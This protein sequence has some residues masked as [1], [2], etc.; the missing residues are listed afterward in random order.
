MV[1]TLFQCELKRVS[2]Q[3]MALKCCANIGL[4]SHHSAPHFHRTISCS[5]YFILNKSWFTTPASPNLPSPVTPP[6]ALDAREIPHFDREQSTREGRRLYIPGPPFQF[7]VRTDQSK[8]KQDWTKMFPHYEDV[9]DRIVFV[10]SYTTSSL[11]QSRIEVMRLYRKIVRGLPQTLTDY[12]AWHISVKKAT[13]RVAT[14]FR[15]NAHV[16]DTR[17]IDKLRIK[18]EQEY[19]GYL[20]GR[21]HENNFYRLFSP[22]E[23]DN[24]V[25]AAVQK[26]QSHARSS[27][28]SNF[29][30]GSDS[31]E[32]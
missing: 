25:P 14:E 29:Y 9:R 23:N 7:A 4:I 32:R 18:A 15:K 19:Q 2:I 1:G 17:V 30:A 26:R 10:P 27:F 5:S 22:E 12:G 3:T 11:A 6:S 8:R 13:G 20:L 24:P 16:R 28:L 31:T 21:H